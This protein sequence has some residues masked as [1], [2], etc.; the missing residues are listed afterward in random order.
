MSPRHAAWCT[1]DLPVARTRAGTCTGSNHLC[2]QC[3][4]A[5]DVR[6][7]N[8]KGS[9][10]HS[11]AEQRSWS[12]YQSRQQ[13]HRLRAHPTRL[14]LT[15]WRAST[16]RSRQLLVS[17]PVGS[18]RPHLQC[19]QARTNQPPRMMSTFCQAQNQLV[20]ARTPP[21]VPL[22]VVLLPYE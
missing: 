13:S 16:D 17:R 11:N 1:A 9:M 21:S 15:A 2:R 5:N 22:S 19:C 12:R 20:S 6:R 14:P 18:H 4:R 10:K 7:Q 8:A 3:R